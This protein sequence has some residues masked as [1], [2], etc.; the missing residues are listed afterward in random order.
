MKSWEVLRDAIEPIGVKAVA[1]EMNLSSALIYKWC[2]EPTEDDPG[3]SGARNPLDRLRTIIELTRDPRIANWVCSVAGGF[4]VANPKV[5]PEDQEEQ[6]LATTQRLVQ[7]F[8]Q[9]L[10]DI[11]RSIANDGQIVPQEAE[12]IRQ[13]WETLKSHAESF[14]V[15]A[16]QALYQH[17]R[18]AGR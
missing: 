7:N 6:M 1:A 17:K 14:V 9:L 10:T 2:Q 12:A 15:A 5:K 18:P 4:F 8:G 13:S 11:S 3:A 16:E